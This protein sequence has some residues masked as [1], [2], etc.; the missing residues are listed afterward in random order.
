MGYYEPSEG[1]FEPHEL[2]IILD[3]YKEKC[4]SILLSEVCQEIK[5]LK[6]ENDSYE[7][8]NKKMS[9]L[10]RSLDKLKSS[11]E[12]N[13]NQIIQDGIAEYQRSALSGLRCGDTIW[14]IEEDDTTEKC[15]RCNGTHK[16]SVNVAG[17]TKKV[18]CPHCQYNGLV[19][20]DKKFIPTQRTIS[21]I[22][23]TIWNE[24]KTFK[25][26]IYCKEIKGT[27]DRCSDEFICDDEYGSDK[28]ACEHN[29]TY[30]SATKVVRRDF[31]I[32]EEE[33]LDACKS[34]YNEWLVKKKNKL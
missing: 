3:E 10:V 16:I 31:Y 20:V 30:G 34:L 12:R 2:E 29:E 22:Q 32:S 4:K 25:R 19:V 24:N 7:E 9:E 13:K 33:C 18:D 14:T 28:D 23:T 27:Q 5:E 26:Y 11:F 21:Q 6:E 1:Y 8:Q 17:V 15:G